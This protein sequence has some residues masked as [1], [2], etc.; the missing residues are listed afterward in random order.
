MGYLK[1][2]WK[3][4]MEKVGRGTEVPTNLA[5]KKLEFKNTEIEMLRMLEY[6]C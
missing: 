6:E 1:W 2:N 5:K 3:F 4:E